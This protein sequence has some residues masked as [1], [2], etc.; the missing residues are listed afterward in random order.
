MQGSCFPPGAPGRNHPPLTARRFP[1]LHRPAPGSG[2]VHADPA[3]AAQAHGIP[4]MAMGPPTVAPP[5][6]SPADGTPPALVQPMR[7]GPPVDRGLS[8]WGPAGPSQRW[9]PGPPSPGT[10]SLPAVRHQAAGGRWQHPRSSAGVSAGCVAA[11]GPLRGKPLHRHS[12][13]YGYRPSG[14]TSHAFANR[15]QRPRNPRHSCGQPSATAGLPTI[16]R[17]SSGVSSQ[18]RKG[19]RAADLHHGPAEADRHVWQQPLPQCETSPASSCSVASE[20]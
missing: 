16:R 13:A 7:T 6:R 9:P 2:R 15:R 20:S 18:W 1:L 14:P 10:E 8:S 17:Q 19:G 4:P 3:L 5:N 11:G 12:C